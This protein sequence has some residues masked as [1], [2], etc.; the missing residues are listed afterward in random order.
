MKQ[1]DRSNT[2]AL[3]DGEQSRLPNG[4]YICKITAAEDVADK[5]YIKIEFDIAAGE[6]K[7]YFSDLFTRAGFWGGR[8]IRSYKDTA[9]KFFNGFLTAVE[10]SNPGYTF[11]WNAKSLVGKMVGIV[12]SEEEYV[13]NA[14]EVK[15]KQVASQ[16]RDIEVIRSGNFK[17]PDLKPLDANGKKRLADLQA[18]GYGGNP[19]KDG[20]IIPSEDVPF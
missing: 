3:Q 15:P 18:K 16:I 10:K 20:T 13:T 19:D 7:G 6:F 1:F 5:E 17:V 4:G 11:D 8:F 14:C 2:E 12:L 9:T